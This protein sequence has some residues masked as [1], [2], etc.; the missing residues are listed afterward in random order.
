MVVFNEL[1]KTKGGEMKV[2]KGIMVVAV[3]MS[4]AGAASASSI[5]AKVWYADATDI[6]DAALLY[7][8]SA[9]ISMGDNLWLSGAFLTGTYD[10]DDTDGNAIRDVDTTDAEIVLGYTANIIDIGVGAR[11]SSWEWEGVEDDFLMFGPM[12]Y[13]GLGNTFGDTDLGWYVGGSYM[14]KDFGDADDKDWDATYE[15]YNVEGGLFLAMES[16]SVTVGY[17]IKEYIDS[18]IDLTFDGAV[19]SL[20]FGF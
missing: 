15:H 20:G 11:I 4:I 19:A 12:V 9:S 2:L 7:G 5:A 13:V 3:I 1:F 14:F 6:E 10:G 18:D 8:G 16:L 17:R